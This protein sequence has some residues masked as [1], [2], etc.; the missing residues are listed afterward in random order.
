[1]ETE[2]QQNE[3]EEEPKDLSMFNEEEEDEGDFDYEAEHP[4]QDGKDA[5][6]VYQELELTLQQEESQSGVTEDIMDV[7]EVVP[8]KTAKKYDDI[9]DGCTVFIRNLSIHSTEESI[10]EG[11]S[12]FGALWYVKCVIDKATGEFKGTAFAK[13]KEA[14]AV[15]AA[16]EESKL[17]FVEVKTNVICL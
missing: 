6:A 17:G 5:Q 10:T 4:M 14:A 16:V 13:F 1:M 9:K 2:E 7:D 11:L 3:H 12:R 8:P 15:I